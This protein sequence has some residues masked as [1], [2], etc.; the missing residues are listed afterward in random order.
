MADNNQTEHSFFPTIINSG[1]GPAGSSW[2]KRVQRE[3]CS[4]PGKIV[5]TLSYDPPDASVTMKP[6]RGFGYVPN[7]PDLI[8]GHPFAPVPGRISDGGV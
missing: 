1:S 4:G 6:R 5:Q 3:C 7:L 2:D 8:P